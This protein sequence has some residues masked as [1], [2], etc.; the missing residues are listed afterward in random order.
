MH[1]NIVEYANLCSMLRAKEA[2]YQIVGK[3]LEREGEG[4]EGGRGGAVG[5]GV[6]MSMRGGFGLVRLVGRSVGRI[7]QKRRWMDRVWWEERQR[8]GGNGV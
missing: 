5:D 1:A 2:E 4:R 6:E 8:D 3:E 7:P